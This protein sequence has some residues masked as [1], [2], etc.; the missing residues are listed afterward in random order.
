MKCSGPS[1]TMKVQIG[2]NNLK[3]YM[4]S[5]DIGGCNILLGIEWIDTLGI[6]PC[7]SRHSLNFNQVKHTYHLNGITSTSPKITSLY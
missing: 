6:S 1:E 7:I 5:I 3:I 2:D 4:F